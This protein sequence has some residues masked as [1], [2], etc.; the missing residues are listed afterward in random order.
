MFARMLCLLAVLAG[1]SLM[2]G[3]GLLVGAAAGTAG[4]AYVSGDL[5]SK[6]QAPPRDV[7]VAAER[8][9]SDFN[10][11]SGPAKV[12]AVD[13]EII[14]HTADDTRVK[15]SADAKDGM[16]TDVSIRVGVFGDEQLSRRIW[17]RMQTYLGQPGPTASTW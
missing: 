11:S 10:I 9:L 8:A 5:E 1:V 14:G 17:D 15:I 13:G 12:T 16:E 4:A 2:G 7:I 3:C 6:T